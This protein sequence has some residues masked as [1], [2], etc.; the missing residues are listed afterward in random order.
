[1]TTRKFGAVG[2]IGKPLAIVNGN[3]LMSTSAV[4]GRVEA[5]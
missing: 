4:A 5:R 1:M 3:A 2:P